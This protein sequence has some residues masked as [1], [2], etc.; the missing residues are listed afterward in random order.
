ML[1]ACQRE[2]CNAKEEK[3]TPATHDLEEWNVKS[4][5]CTESG[6]KSVSCMD[7]TYS[8]VVVLPAK[9]HTYSEWVELLPATCSERG[10]NIKI[11]NDCNDI[12]RQ[13]IPKL[14]HIDAD[15]NGV[16]DTCENTD[17]PDVPDTPDEPDTPNVPDTP[18][19]P[20]VPEDPSANCSCNCHKG[21][22]SKIIFNIILFFQKLLRSNKTCSCGASH[23]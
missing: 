17:T 9:G 18:N 16:C 15:G 10:L 8:A 1:R 19:E 4:P 23:Y 2:G 20:D 13:I 3:V 14:A 21:G 7:C 22:L 6:E 11:C 5:T 12:Q